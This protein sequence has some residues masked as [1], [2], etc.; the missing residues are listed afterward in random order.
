MV[1][2][3]SDNGWTQTSGTLPKI[4]SCEFSY[5]DFFR[6]SY[7]VFWVSTSIVAVTSTNC[8]IVNQKSYR[9]LL[10]AILLTFLN[11]PFFLYQFGIYDYFDFF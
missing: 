1:N 10:D 3:S 4:I 6:I 5:L 9:F 11:Y 2:A 8:S 7:R